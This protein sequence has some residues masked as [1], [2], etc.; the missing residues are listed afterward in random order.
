[1]SVAAAPQL[2]Q[3][4]GV[5]HDRASH[6]EV[7]NHC[8]GIKPAGGARETSLDYM[9]GD[10][11]AEDRRVACEAVIQSGTSRAARA[12]LPLRARRC[13]SICRSWSPT[14]SHAP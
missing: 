9:Q 11:D 12:D 3:R 5:Q 14:A 1:M 8:H 10:S 6:R 7:W 2:A 13:F 4:Q